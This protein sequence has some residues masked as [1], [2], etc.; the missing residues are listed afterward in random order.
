MRQAA[1]FILVFLS[2]NLPV[3]NPTRGQ[4]DLS[5]TAQDKNDAK[6]IK[7]QDRADGRKA[8]EA[9]AADVKPSEGKQREA[10][11]SEAKQSE[12]KPQAADFGKYYP[13]KVLSQ[14]SFQGL[15]YDLKKDQRK[16]FVASSFNAG[17]VLGID[18]IEL[19][20]SFIANEFEANGIKVSDESKVNER[21]DGYVKAAEKKVTLVQILVDDLPPLGDAGARTDE[22]KERLRWANR[23][24]CAFVVIRVD[25]KTLATENKLKDLKP[26]QKMIRKAVGEIAKGGKSTAN[27]NS[28]ALLIEPSRGLSTNAEDTNALIDDLRSQPETNRSRMCLNLSAAADDTGYFWKLCTRNVRAVAIE[29]FR[30]QG[31]KEF[32]RDYAYI[33][34]SVFVTGVPGDFNGVVVIR[35]LGAGPY[36]EGIPASL[37]LVDDIFK[38][39]PS[40]VKNVEQPADPKA[41]PN[42]A[43]KQ[44]K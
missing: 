6:P 27:A 44:D 21:L 4:M 35:F 37:K 33:F 8:G 40:A 31:T 7:G 20:S 11:L 14:L 5:A 10:K 29:T 19:C 1:A 41:K 3:S 43:E 42:S 39:I 9:D 16:N 12:A 30:F 38:T 36:Y 24:G 18:G 32:S 13:R 26:E 25:H 22:Y 34:K 2:M 15:F 17:K 23:L 28:A